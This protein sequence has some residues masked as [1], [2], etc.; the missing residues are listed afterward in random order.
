MNMK[1][2][3]LIIT[4]IVTF[5]VTSG[6]SQKAKVRE[7]NKEYDNFAYLKTSDILLEVANNGYKSVDLLQKL[8]NSFYFNNK[9]E[10]AAKWYGEL[11]AMNEIVDAEY[12]FRYALALKSSENYLESD[13]WMQKF[14]EVNRSDLRGKVFASRVDYL[15]KIEEA[16]RD[17]EVKN[18]E[19]NSEL[20]DFGSTEYK[21]QLIFASTRGGGKKYGWN[22][23]PFLDLYST[24][25]QEDGSYA[26]VTEFGDDINTKYH[27][28]TAAFTPDAN[29]MYFTRNNYFKGKA[30]KDDNGTN[31]LKIYKA[32]FKNGKWED[33]ESIIFNSDQYSVA[34]PS[35]NSKGNRMFFAS[36]MIGSLGSS[37]IFVVSINSDGTLG[38]PQ[39]LGATVN[40]EGTESFPFVNSVGDLYFS[41]NGF[42]GLGGLDVFV[43]RDFENKYELR[44]PMILENI[45]KPINSPKDDFGYYENLVTEQGFFTSNRDGGKG[46]DDIYTF[47]IPECKQVIDGVVRDEITQELIDRAVVSLFD[48]NGI[49]VD[50]TLVGPDAVFSFDVECDKEYLIRVDKDTYTSDEVRVNTPNSKQELK[51]EMNLKQDEQKIE[52][53]TDLA[54]TL[55]IPIIYFDFDKS[56]IRLDAE[57]ELQKVIA[58]L[59]KYPTM[60]IDVRSHT[61]SR[62]SFE[63]NNTLSKKR[64]KSTLDYI[65]KKGGISKDRLTGD[66]YGESQ[67]VNKCSDGVECTEAEH[68]LNRRSEFI[69]LNM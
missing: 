63:Y 3:R 67:L 30:K 2:N 45:G 64:N 27:E 60:K 26:N 31:R 15:A 9:M 69:I 55:G 44:Q 5:I 57:V 4:L 13:K 7:A 65:I 42:T 10:E 18:L 51:M 53:G 33:L 25:K 8:G 35:I 38:E 47:K 24:D 52:P 32:T 58:V 29:T 36:D 46:D 6:F 22:E 41:S 54:K 23:Q 48:E 66:G 34:H 1:A 62:A 19:I 49:E 40:T 56:N 68:Q 43:I 16:S 17:F 39:N 50:R 20:S 21:N 37:D 61:D 12:Y 59:K 14:H 28:S 11:M